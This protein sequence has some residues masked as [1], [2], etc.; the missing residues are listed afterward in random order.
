MEGIGQFEWGAHI[1][2]NGTILKEDKGTNRGIE[3]RE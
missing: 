2:F 1:R 3:C